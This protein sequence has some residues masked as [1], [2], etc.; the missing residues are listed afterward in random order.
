MKFNS[1]KV[2]IVLFNTLFYLS[3]TKSLNL[4]LQN[5][6]LCDKSKTQESF[7][8]KNYFKANSESLKQKNI[9][10]IVEE[11]KK[12]FEKVENEDV[13]LFFLV[14]FFSNQTLLY[15]S[16]EKFFFCIQKTNELSLNLNKNFNY[17]E[18]GGKYKV[19]SF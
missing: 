2:F 18:N 16:R 3:Q 8:Q 12:I 6:E 1:R 5:S 7:H 13:S 19:I 11:V 9:N 4:N 14:K 10:K 15:F 17:P